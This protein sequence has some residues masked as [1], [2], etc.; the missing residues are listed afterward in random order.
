[1]HFAFLQHYDISFSC[2]YL[3]R[4]FPAV[5]LPEI[6]QQYK[7]GGPHAAVARDTQCVLSG[8]SDWVGG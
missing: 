5:F 7:G 3:I 4:F 2:C 1:M 8:F 6:R